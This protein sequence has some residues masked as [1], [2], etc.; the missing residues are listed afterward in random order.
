M[1]IKVACPKCKKSLVAKEEM[2]GRTVRCPQCQQPLKLPGAAQ[3]KPSTAAMGIAASAGRPAPPSVPQTPVRQM[4]ADP[5]PS[6][7]D[8]EYALD[9]PTAIGPPCPGCR[10]PFPTDKVLCIECGYHR[11]QGKKIGPARPVV[12]TQGDSGIAPEGIT[13]ARKK[14]KSSTSGGSR[15][16]EAVAGLMLMVSTGL[17]LYW[18]IVYKQK[19]YFVPLG[20]F[21]SGFGSFVRGIS[22][23]S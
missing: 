18:G 13:Q 12:Q 16:Y 20:L 17:L 3:A 6:L 15:D 21:I 8:E 23:G 2:A 10:R 11:K 4:T 1:A 7:F 9:T 14:K 19:L 22:R 5:L